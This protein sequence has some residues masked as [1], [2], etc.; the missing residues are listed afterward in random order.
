MRRC[1]FL[2]KLVLSASL[3]LAGGTVL[4]S[5][6]INTLASIN[7]CGT[8]FTVCTPVDQLNL[9]FPMLELP[10]FDADGRLTLDS[11]T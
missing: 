9:L 2:K 4:G 5:G 11:E 3:V 10:D 1:R 8:V 6:C 7:L